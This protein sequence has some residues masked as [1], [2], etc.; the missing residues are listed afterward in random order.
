[1]KRIIFFSFDKDHL[2][3]IDAYINVHSQ[4]VLAFP[5]SDLSRLNSENYHTREI[6]KDEIKHRVHQKS[7]K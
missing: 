5:L 6:D 2:D 7:I 4:R 3:L 1:M